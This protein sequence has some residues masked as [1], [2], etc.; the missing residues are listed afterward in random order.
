MRK[1]SLSD[2]RFT[3]RHLAAAVADLLS[4]GPIVVSSQVL[5][6]GALGFAENLTIYDAV[7]LVLATARGIPL[8]TCDGGLA[9]IA[10]GA[11]VPVLVPGRDPLLP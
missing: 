6:E 5:V 8:C 2:E 10:K 9:A 7:Y 1:R 4:L 11:G 3:R